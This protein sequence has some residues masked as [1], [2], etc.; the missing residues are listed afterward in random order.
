MDRGVTLYGIH[1]ALYFFAGMLADCIMAK[2][3]IPFWMAG[4][5]K[6]PGGF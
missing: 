1:F 6:Q 4:N 5:N 3:D 2:Y